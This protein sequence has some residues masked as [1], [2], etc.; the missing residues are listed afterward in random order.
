[1]ITCTANAKVAMENRRPDIARIWETCEHLARETYSML[2]N[3]FH[4]NKINGISVRSSNAHDSTKL[5]RH[6]MM[7]KMLNQLILK[8]IEGSVMD[9]QTAAMIICA[10]TPNRKQ[11]RKTR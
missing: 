6:P 3:G 5:K 9:F 2:D 7:V 8:L 11:A 10:F 4:G 1:M